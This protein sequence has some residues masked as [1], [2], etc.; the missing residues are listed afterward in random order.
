M[1]LTIEGFDKLL[2]KLNVV[3]TDTTKKMAFS[4]VAVTAAEGRK[5]EQQRATTLRFGLRQHSARKRKNGKYEFLDRVMLKYTPAGLSSTTR[6]TTNPKTGAVTPYRM[7]NF[8]WET[9]RRKTSATAGYT[10]ILANLWAHPSKP[11]SAD[12]PFVGSG[13]YRKQWKEGQSRPSKYSWSSV[14][15]ILAQ[16]MGTGVTVTEQR[17]KK[18]F[19]EFNKE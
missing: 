10:S 19:E 14:A 16:H 4:A 17:F 18:D 1:E 15:S 6:T 5:E 7:A 13:R 8:S 9:V 12:S 2:N 3:S 11:Y